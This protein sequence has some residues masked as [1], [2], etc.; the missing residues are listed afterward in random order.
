[1]RALALVT[2]CTVI[3]CSVLAMQHEAEVAH[4]RDSTGVQVH[5]SSV[6]CHDATQRTH[7]HTLPSESAH[8]PG[9]C[10]L[11]AAVHQVAIARP[12]VTVALVKPVVATV[13]PPAVTYARQAPLLHAAPKTSPP[14]A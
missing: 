7:M 1:M 3:A 5:A 14:R 9:A 12:P 8:D 2:A 13:T 4:V 10:A 11:I 6:D